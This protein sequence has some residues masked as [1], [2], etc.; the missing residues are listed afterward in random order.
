MRIFILSLPFLFSGCAAEVITNADSG[1]YG[2]ASSQTPRQGEVAYNPDG[3]KDLVD[4]R[5]E[6]A[7]KKIYNICGSN[8]YKILKEEI[9][10]PRALVSGGFATIG[11]TR[12]NHIHFECF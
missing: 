11:A 9:V 2:P 7:M 8:N 6:D 12:L 4:R 3:I 5:R 1:P 10:K